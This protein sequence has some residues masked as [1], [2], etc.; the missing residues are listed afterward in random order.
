MNNPITILGCV[1]KGVE[2]G[3]VI[4]IAADGKEYS[5]HGDSIPTIGRGLGVSVTGT[6][7]GVSTCLQGTPLRVTSWDWTRERCPE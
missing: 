7:G 3:C 5:L 6:L 4:L 1:K 2:P